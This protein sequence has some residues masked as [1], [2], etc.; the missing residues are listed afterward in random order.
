MAA[1]ISLHVA[2]IKLSID[3]GY[4]PVKYTVVLKQTPESFSVR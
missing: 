2:L 3:Q 1:N 4:Q